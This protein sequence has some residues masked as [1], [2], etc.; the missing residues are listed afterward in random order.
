MYDH[1]A[2]D[3]QLQTLTTVSP[4]SP[5]PFITGQIKIEL[6]YL[7]LLPPSPYH[8]IIGQIE[9]DLINLEDEFNSQLP[10]NLVAA[11]LYLTLILY[12]YRREKGKRRT[13]V[14]VKMTERL[15]HSEV[16]YPLTTPTMFAASLYR[17]I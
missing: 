5:C 6:T 17:L 13:C 12:T 14:T 15:K 9:V 7:T 2:V 8:L 4:P 11:S 16:K 10:I 3:V 1:T